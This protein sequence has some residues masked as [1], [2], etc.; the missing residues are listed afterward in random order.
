[1]SSVPELHIY[2]LLG[3]NTDSANRDKKQNVA[4]GWS[5]H[6]A[7]RVSFFLLSFHRHGLVSIGLCVLI[8]VSCVCL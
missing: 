5:S 1:M 7:F 8:S 3:T 6:E 4:A 2:T